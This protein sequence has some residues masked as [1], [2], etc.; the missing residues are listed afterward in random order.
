[1]ELILVPNS[2]LLYLQC[3]DVSSLK[4]KRLFLEKSLNC[5]HARGFK[6][7]FYVLGVL[8]QNS[9]HPF[10]AETVGCLAYE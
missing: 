9:S 8:D 4:G 3:N 2:S 1:M 5:R 7:Y 10:I 6:L